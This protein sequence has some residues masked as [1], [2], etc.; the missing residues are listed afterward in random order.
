MGWLRQDIRLVYPTAK[1]LIVTDY[2]DDT[3]RS[4]A[5]KAGACGYALKLN[6]LDLAALIR[7]ATGM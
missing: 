3:L 5:Q 1:I 7:S 2:D 6:L 4:A